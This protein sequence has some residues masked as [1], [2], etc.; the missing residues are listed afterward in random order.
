MT[1]MVHVDR[2]P[3]TCLIAVCMVFLSSSMFGALTMAMT[4]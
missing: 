4:S 2:I 3:F 1:T